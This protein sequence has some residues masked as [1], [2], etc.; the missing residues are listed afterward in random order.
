[1][2]SISQLKLPN[3]ST[4]DLKDAEAREQIGN[5]PE[6]KSD[7]NNNVTVEPGIFQD[8]HV[9][10]DSPFTTT[11]NVVATLYT[12][13]DNMNRSQLSCQIVSISTTGFVL[14]IFNPTNITFK[15]GYTWIAT[16]ADR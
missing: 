6:I 16:T 5:M 2:A 8:L 15:V 10:F 1:M 12:T 4:Y 13:S 11:P 7:F 9:S 3:G 14:R